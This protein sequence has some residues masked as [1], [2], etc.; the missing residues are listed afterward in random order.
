[1]AL[2]TDHE[3]FVQ[4]SF[5]CNFHFNRFYHS[6][7]YNYVFVIWLTQKL[8]R[9]PAATSLMNEDVRLPLTEFIISILKF[10]GLDIRCT[11]KTAFGLKVFLKIL[12]TFLKHF[13]VVLNTKFNFQKYF[14]AHIPL[15]IVK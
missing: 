15:I 14:T 3:I 6:R 12:I 1:M 4:D 10:S 11:R 5:I 13:K 8:C 9:T 7:L 2:F